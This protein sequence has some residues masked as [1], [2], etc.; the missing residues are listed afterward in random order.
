M[1]A[2]GIE[3]M[4]G[5]LR[6]TA[7]RAA[8]HAPPPTQSSVDADFA[9]FV[10]GALRQVSEMEEHADRMADG[11]SSGDPD[12]NLQDVMVQLQKADLSFQQVV[13]MRNRLVSAYQDVMN[14]SV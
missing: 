3:S 11:F 5:A 6:A 2:S 13:Q 4:L 14:M 7:S 9:Q 10:L 1:N 12:V 8:G